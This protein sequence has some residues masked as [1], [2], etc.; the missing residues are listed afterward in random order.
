MKRIAT[1]FLTIILLL[2]ST[3]S[4]AIEK[5]VNTTITDS[6]WTAITLGTGQTC[7][8]YAFQS[9]DGSAFKVSDTATGT[10]YWTVKENAGLT[11]TENY[12]VPG[13]TLFYAQSSSGSIVIE[14]FILNQ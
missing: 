5:P 1:I 9:R 11:A 3:V 13:G 2:I 10:K 14:D 4:F 6:T 7:S 12:G 8:S